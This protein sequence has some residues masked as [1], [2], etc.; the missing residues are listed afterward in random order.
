M[1]NLITTDGSKFSQA[2]IDACRNI[3]TAPENTSFKIISAVEFPTMLPSD[4]FI[5][6]SADYYD[7]FEQN[8]HSLAEEFTQPAETQLRALFAGVSLDISTEVIDGSPQRV[9]VEEAEKWNA[10]LI[11]VGSHVYG[12]WSRT[13]LGSVSSSIVHH[14]VCSVLV[15]RAAQDSNVSSN[16]NK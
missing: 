15:V 14:A 2:A 8:G 7:Q 16:L 11:V 12:F 6:A 9:I 10:D 3:A 4:P 13:L 5:G 1:K